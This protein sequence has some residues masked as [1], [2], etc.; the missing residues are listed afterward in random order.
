MRAKTPQIK[1]RVFLLCMCW[2]L[3]LLW[4]YHGAFRVLLQVWELVHALAQ[5]ES[6]FFY[7]VLCFQDGEEP[8]S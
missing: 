6:F 2:S 7:K 4:K 3:T 1:Y 8:K 5:H